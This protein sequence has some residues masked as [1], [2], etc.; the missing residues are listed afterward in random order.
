MCLESGHV[1]IAIWEQTEPLPVYI[2][3]YSKSDDFPTQIPHP[4]KRYTARG[5]GPTLPAPVVRMT[6]VLANSLKLVCMFAPY[7]DKRA[8]QEAQI[9]PFQT[10]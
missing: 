6:A 10:N 1:Y 5:W 4:R 9:T 7:P 3:I 8:G 2:Y